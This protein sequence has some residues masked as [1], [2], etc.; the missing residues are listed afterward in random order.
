MTKWAL[1]IIIVLGTILSLGLGLWAT[2]TEVTT[3]D[4]LLLAL[5]QACAQA[6]DLQ[7]GSQVLCNQVKER[8]KEE[9]QK[10]LEQ[11]KSIKLDPDLLGEALA[12]TAQQA[13]SGMGVDEALQLALGLTKMLDQGAYGKKLHELLAYGQATGYSPEEMAVLVTQLAEMATTQSSAGKVLDAALGHLDK[14]GP[15]ETPERVVEAIQQAMNNH[16]MPSQDVSSLGNDQKIPSV[17]DQPKD[18]P[19]KGPDLG[20]QPPSDK[21][22]AAEVSALPSTDEEEE[23]GTPQEEQGHK[24]KGT[25][26]KENSGKGK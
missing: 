26:K 14:A 23:A 16:E 5:D 13:R 4:Q 21:V 17:V 25:A 12:W 22:G 2:P 18:Q 3:Q 9:L 11:H 24:T 10:Q 7:T 20:H 19:E 6:G 15:G 8:L 1:G